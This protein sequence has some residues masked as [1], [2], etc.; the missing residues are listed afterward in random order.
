MDDKP[1]IIEEAPKIDSK[2]IEPNDQSAIETTDQKASQT[3]N[4]EKSQKLG[5]NDVNVS[6]F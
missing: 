6:T 2:P 4:V 5:T 1:K 3:V